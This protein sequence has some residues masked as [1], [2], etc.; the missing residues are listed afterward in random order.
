M[1]FSLHPE[2][3]FRFSFSVIENYL[4]R[5]WT[6]KQLQIF[7]KYFKRDNPLTRHLYSCYA[8]TIIFWL[9]K[10]KLRT[11]WN[12]SLVAILKGILC[13]LRQFLVGKSCPNYFIP[14]IVSRILVCKELI[15]I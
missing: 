12:D 3:E 1:W 15:L 11:S 7:K 2:T 13:K 4:M 9:I 5:L 14:R 8:R 10:Q 6:K